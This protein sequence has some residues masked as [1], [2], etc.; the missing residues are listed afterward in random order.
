[1]ERLQP[2][3]NAAPRRPEP[4]ALG[5]RRSRTAIAAALVSACL[6][7]PSLV[8]RTIWIPD[9]T[10]YADVAQGML[11]SGDWITPTLG[12]APYPE[13]PPFF[14]WVTA[15]LAA[16]G[17]PLELAPR[18]VS[19]AAGILTV[20]LV[21]I[22]GSALG[23][24]TPLAGRAALLLATLPFFLAYAQM[25]ILD[26]GLTLLV[27]LAIA[28]KLLRARVRAG[29][30]AALALLEG[31]ALGAAL[32]T[33]GP[34]ALLYPLGLRLGGLAAGPA[35]PA[36]P[37]RGDVFAGSLALAIALVWL[38]LV[39]RENG[40]D[41][42]LA[43]TVGQLSRRVIG[44]LQTPHARPP[45]F[46]GVC[47]LLALLPWTAFG[48]SA[49]RRLRAMPRA[50]ARAEGGPLLGWLVVPV[51]LLTLLP[52]QQPHYALPV[53]PAA[54]LLLA[55]A[56]FAAPGRVALRAL[57]ALAVGLG[58]GLVAVG[59]ASASGLV[60]RSAH[61]AVEF[62][63]GDAGVRAIA[64]SIGFLLLALCVAPARRLGATARI[65]TAAAGAFLGA[66]LLVARL[67]P[68]LHP[69]ELLA[70]PEIARARQVIAPSTLRSALRL[71]TPH[72][73]IVKINDD[74]VR[75][76]LRFHP[77]V[78]VL[79]WQEDLERIL[80]PAP[81]GGDAGVEQIGS[82]FVRGKR[83]VLLRASRGPE[84]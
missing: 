74:H 6:L 54:A 11:E 76:A 52:S 7:A 15:S 19:V 14:F 47:T 57:G 67:N 34:V 50:L 46:L 69:A 39:W 48:A 41:Y 72:R 80:G 26:A 83:L 27:T 5:V 32:L 1:M 24:A 49:L 61:P 58:A 22:I 42:A 28:A 71:A 18:A 66:L 77:D 10:R 21:P 82:G 37:D 12:G 16:V 33:K 45:G 43:L 62:A 79:L 59:L 70:H 68:V 84:P 17:L 2:G 35:S 31:V 13:K 63:R 60:P 25:G 65:G 3:E 78:V 44:D 73:E 36:R 51:L 8:L 4:R 55:P 23:M 81:H 75:K 9:E 64:L 40:Q 56:T 30:R 53:L 20:A 38:S 29:R